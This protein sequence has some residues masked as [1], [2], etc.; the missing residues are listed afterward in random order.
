MAISALGLGTS[1]DSH[2]MLRVN[3]SEGG[4]AAEGGELGEFCA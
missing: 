3:D 1:R 2:A 4:D